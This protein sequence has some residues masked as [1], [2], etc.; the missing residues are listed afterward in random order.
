MHALFPCAAATTR[1]RRAP[2]VTTDQCPLPSPSVS[3]TTHPPS[4]PV[5]PPRRPHMPPPRLRTRRHGLRYSFSLPPAAST[6]TCRTAPL[7]PPPSPSP[8][9]FRPTPQ[10]AQ[11]PP[12]PTQYHTLGG[13]SDENRKSVN[14][15]GCNIIM[16]SPPGH[17]FG[18]FHTH[19]HLPLAS[20][21]CIRGHAPSSHR[22]PP[23]P[24]PPMPPPMSG[25]R[26]FTYAPL[27]RTLISRH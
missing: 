20:V 21:T 5:D 13:L 15:R 17:Y 2:T 16:R 4:P 23:P 12:L 22:H 1:A 26:W 14:V 3:T 8:P 7:R 11:P 19:S 9:Q 6:H 27:G 24:P 25:A 18:W 10:G